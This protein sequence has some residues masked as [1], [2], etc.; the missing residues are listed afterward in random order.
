MDFRKVWQWNTS[1]REY[2]CASWLSQSCS[3]TRSGLAAG[4]RRT[5]S[6]LDAQGARSFC[7]WSHSIRP[8]R[9]VTSGASQ[10]SAARLYRRGGKTVWHLADSKSLRVRPQPRTFACGSSGLLLRMPAAFFPC[11]RILDVLVPVSF[12]TASTGVL[13]GRLISCAHRSQPPEL[14]Q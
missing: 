9:W 4:C 8:R 12:A 5:D 3:S 7:V 6:R 1:D 2:S 11:L 10:T 14:K 13:T